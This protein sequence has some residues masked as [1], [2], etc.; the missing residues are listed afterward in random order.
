MFIMHMP[1]SFK[2]GDTDADNSEYSVEEVPG[3]GFII[4]AKPKG[5]AP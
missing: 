1:E 5:A 3:E 2:V 4:F